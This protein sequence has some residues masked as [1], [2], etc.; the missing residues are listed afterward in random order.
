MN[1]TGGRLQQSR[2][3]KGGLTAE[4]K[5]YFARARVKQLSRDDPRPSLD[6]SVFGNVTIQRGKRKRSTLEIA[7]GRQETPVSKPKKLDLRSTP[8]AVGQSGF[9]NH[10]S[11]HNK[12]HEKQN[13]RVVQA[14]DAAIERKR[15]KLLRRQDWLVSSIARPLQIQPTKRH[16]HKKTARRRKLDN[17]DIM[18]LKQQRR[19]KR[20]EVSIKPYPLPHCSQSQHD[21]VS[22]RHGTQIHG[23]QMTQYVTQT[24][25]K[26]ASILATTSPGEMLFDSSQGSAITQRPLMREPYLSISR[27][28]P[29]APTHCN[30]LIA[31]Q[32]QLLEAFRHDPQMPHVPTLQSQDSTDNV[33]G[34]ETADSC[35]TEKSS[36]AVPTEQSASPE[37]GDEALMNSFDLR[38]AFQNGQNR[39]QTSIWTQE[40]VDSCTNFDFSAHVAPSSSGNN[41][42]GNHD[43][44]P[45]QD[46]PEAAK[47][48]PEHLSFQQH[49]FDQ[50]IIDSEQA[51]ELSLPTHTPV[52][53]YRSDLLPGSSR[54]SPDSTERQEIDNGLTDQCAEPLFTVERRQHD[55]FET[56]GKRLNESDSSRHNRRR[57]SSLI[58]PRIPRGLS[59]LEETDDAC[60]KS[61]FDSLADPHIA[62]DRTEHLESSWDSCLAQAPSTGRSEVALA[63]PQNSPLKSMAVQVS[64]SPCTASSPHPLVK[65]HR[66]VPRYKRDQSHRRSVRSSSTDPLARWPE[67]RDTFES[68]VANAGTQS[69]V[70]GN[71]ETESGDELA[72]SSVAVA[73]STARCGKADAGHERIIFTKPPRFDGGFG[74]KNTNTLRIGRRLDAE[75]YPEKLGRRAQG[76]NGKGQNP[77]SRQH[78]EPQTGNKR[79]KRTRERQDEIED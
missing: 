63:C 6:L 62:A 68:M 23:S 69:K 21:T 18:R 41:Y 66:A 33:L 49:N 4:Q 8:L 29:Y 15:Q 38:P 1:W 67:S 42:D 77:D 61:V 31:Q 71:R 5:A 25:V 65:A 35:N 76:R 50:E 30:T 64:S 48:V 27:S 16:E 20:R 28:S 79:W 51:T 56:Y 13:H 53:K 2:R 44:H 7:C 54:V 75:E 26:R 37:Q 52:L 45:S 47:E 55:R 43:E 11:H 22:I 34:Q 17:D 19:N 57:T 78:S 3:A 36:V 9:G 74:A 60:Y 73:G 10:C 59:P 70:R 12:I 58:N 40:G 39:E 14:E 32:Q 24:P 72:A 46:A